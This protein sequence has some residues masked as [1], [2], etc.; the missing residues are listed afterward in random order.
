MR[1]RNKKLRRRLRDLTDKEVEEFFL[2]S[3][4][5]DTANSGPDLGPDVV[6]NEPYSKIYALPYNPTWEIPRDSIELGTMFFKSIIPA[7]LLLRLI[8]RLFLFFRT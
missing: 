7:I 2:G 4:N 3:L 5:P 6:Q 8:L 1:E